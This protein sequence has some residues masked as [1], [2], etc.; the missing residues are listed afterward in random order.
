VFVYQIEEI[1]KITREIPATGSTGKN[2]DSRKSK[3]F[4]LYLD[5]GIALWISGDPYPMNTLTVTP[6]Y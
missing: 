2:S 1:E 4:E 3:G 6:G 5:E